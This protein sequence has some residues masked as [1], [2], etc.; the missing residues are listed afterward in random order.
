MVMAVE[1]KGRVMKIID[2]GNQ[3]AFENECFRD[4]LNII[5]ARCDYELRRG[6]PLKYWRELFDAGKCEN[7]AIRLV[8]GDTQILRAV[9]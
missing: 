2:L 1:T 9:Q 7:D 6:I 8:F 3:V 4:W 5:D